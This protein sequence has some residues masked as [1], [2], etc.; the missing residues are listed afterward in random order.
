MNESKISVHYAR[1]LFKLAKEKDILKQIADDSTLLFESINTSAEFHK[2]LKDPLMYPSKKKAIMQ[3]TF[4][5]NISEISMDFLNLIFTKQREEY[6]PLILR[7]YLSY[8]RKE[9]GIKEAT[10]TT[11]VPLSESVSQTLTEKISRRL[12]TQVDLTQYTN[13]E[14]IGGFILRIEDMQIDASLA[15]HL[16]HIRQRLVKARY[17]INA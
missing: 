8:Y 14:V 5:D 11:A 6:L 7:N 3:Q 13:R 16:R 9:T 10:I 1:A 12:N 4:A 17:N 15:T 2:F